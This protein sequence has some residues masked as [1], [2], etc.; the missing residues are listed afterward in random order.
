MSYALCA[1]RVS[2]NC[3]CIMY[4]TQIKHSLR[5]VLLHSL[6]A[7]IWLEKGAWFVQIHEQLGNDLNILMYDAFLVLL[8][9]KLLRVMLIQVVFKIFACYLETLHIISTFVLSWSCH[10]LEIFNGAYL[11]LSLEPEKKKK[12]KRKSC[13]T[14]YS[15]A[16]LTVNTRLM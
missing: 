14:V 10:T 5:R 4:L 15:S 7:E 2:F 11:T 12:E 6:P 13:I 16:I 9:Q 8:F 3:R 1:G